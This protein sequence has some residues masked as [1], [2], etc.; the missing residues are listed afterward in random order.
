VHPDGPLIRLRAAR[1][2]SSTA[3]AGLAAAL[4]LVAPSLAALSLAAPALVPSAAAAAVAAGIDGISDQNI[5][6]WD[7]TYAGP[8]F[9]YPYFLRT[10]V[11]SPPS[12]I[13]YAR[14][15]VPWD[16]M[17]DPF[18]DRNRYQ[19]L[20]AWYRAVTA[21]GLI[22]D[23]SLGIGAPMS[24]GGGESLAP[25]PASAAQ[26]EQYVAMLLDDPQLAGVLYLEPWNEPNWGPNRIPAARAAEYWSAASALCAGRC[27][28]IAGN[29]HDDAPDEP[30]LEAYEREYRD[31]LAGQPLDWAIHPYYAIAR[32]TLAPVQA[33]LRNLPE[34]AVDSLWFTEAGAYCET[35]A[36]QVAGAAYLMNA[37]IP[38][39]AP[40]H[41][42]YYDF[43]DRDRV[44]PPCTHGSEDSALYVPSDDPNAPDVP[45]PAA[46]LIFG[47]GRMPWA[48]TGAASLARVGGSAPASGSARVSGS[49][50]VSGSGRVSGSTRVSGS[51]Y[52]DG[53]PTGF[54]FEYGSTPR[55]GSYTP[56]ASA[57]AGEGG[58]RIAGR[59]AGL[60]PGAAYHYRLVAW[61]AEGASYGED[62]TLIA[63]P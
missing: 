20:L 29:L 42:F 23:V 44:L 10:W 43:L 56:A 26:Y 45:R 4:S 31:R 46:A 16:V 37:L 38:A 8:P 52:P 34:P 17:A 53:L 62:R 5:P 48:F 2:R 27:I 49:A 40:T 63:S 11:G 61:N 36:A 54:H 55:Y 19:T 58:V 41:A 39:F 51:V 7:N 28:A 6:T 32:R 59:L 60:A 50:P 12:H 47:G 22:P 25:A 3:L 15:V 14:I 33:F 1:A 57:G 35:T 24:T 18:D 13:R 9:F 21:A 30:A